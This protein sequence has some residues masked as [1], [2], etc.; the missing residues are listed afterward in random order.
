MAEGLWLGGVGISSRESRSRSKRRTTTAS[1]SSSISDRGRAQP[2]HQ[3]TAGIY[4]LNSRNIYTHTY[5]YTNSSTISN[6]PAHI[7]PHLI[8][9]Q[10]INPPSLL[11]RS[12]TCPGETGES[13][14]QCMVLL[15]GVVSI[16]VA[17]PGQCCRDAGTHL[18]PHCHPTRH[19]AVRDGS[20]HRTH[21]GG[22]EMEGPE[23]DVC[24]DSDLLLHHRQW[25]CRFCSSHL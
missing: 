5:T 8:L 25:P 22:S 7:R 17:Q 15:Q 13:S 6:P 21:K 3:P 14:C 9:D 18:W 4:T 19:H 24:R 16:N 23:L 20:L 12:Q 11:D 2:T 1:S 10:P